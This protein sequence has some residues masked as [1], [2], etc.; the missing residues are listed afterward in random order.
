MRKTT[1]LSPSLLDQLVVAGLGANVH[2]AVTI[3]L[4]S[5]ILCCRAALI[6]VGTAATPATTRLT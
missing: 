1:L 3:A 5:V 6:A 4:L 2:V